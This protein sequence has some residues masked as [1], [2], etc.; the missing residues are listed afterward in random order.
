MANL[1][2]VPLLNAVNRPLYQWIVDAIEADAAVAA[3]DAAEGAAWAEAVVEQGPTAMATLEAELRRMR[4]YVKA[5]VEIREFFSS[6]LFG[7]VGGDLPR[8]TWDAAAT[9][10]VA[11]GEWTRAEADAV[12]AF[13]DQP[14]RTRREAAGLRIAI[15][16][17]RW[18][19][20]MDVRDVEAK[21]IAQTRADAA[22]YQAALKAR[23]ASR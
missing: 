9:A 4:L 17:G 13:L 22:L 3:M 11:A 7:A 5:P 2:A 15:T 21:E 18:Q 14:R 20:A 19:D 8:A 16:P 1:D 10:A 23:R 12:A 6:G